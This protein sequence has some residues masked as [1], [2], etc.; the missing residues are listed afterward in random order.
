MNPLSKVNKQLLEDFSL[1]V[2]KE[3]EAISEVISYL[4]YIWARKLYAEAGYSSLFHFLVE[5]YHYSEGAAY[6]RIQGAK[7]YQKFPEIL[8]LLKNGK[9]NLMTLSLIEPHLN[10]KNGSSLINRVLNKSKRE[11][12]EILSELSLKKEKIQDVIRRLPLKREF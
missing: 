7:V 5:K 4:S 10:Q 11:V 3:R 2:L 8:E 12:E 9:L 1:A 6:R